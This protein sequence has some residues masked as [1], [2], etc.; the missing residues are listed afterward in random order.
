MGFRCSKRVARFPQTGA[1]YRRLS[2]LCGRPRRLSP[3]DVLGTPWMH[4]NAYTHAASEGGRHSGNPACQRFWQSLFAV[5]STLR[6]DFR[7]PARRPEH[8]MRGNDFPMPR[9][10]RRFSFFRVRA[11]HRQRCTAAIPRD[12][13]GSRCTHSMSCHVN[14]WRSLVP[15]GAIMLGAFESCRVIRSLP[16][17]VANLNTPGLIVYC[18][19]YRRRG[20]AVLLR[21]FVFV[22]ELLPLLLLYSLTESD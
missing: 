9:R 1:S 13:S 2:T 22:F 7:Y 12:A 20:V 18:E 10:A 15:R 11:A 21:I 14:C 16:N 3:R 6:G 5:P 19:D 4:V 17:A 8:L